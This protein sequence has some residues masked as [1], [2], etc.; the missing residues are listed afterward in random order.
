MPD[1]LPPTPRTEQHAGR[2]WDESP[3]ARYGLAAASAAAAALLTAALRFTAG[4]QNA[5]VIFAFFY[6]AVFVAVWFGGRGP[7]L[8]A[9][10]LSVVIADIFFLNSSILAPDLSGLIPNVFFVGISLIAVLLIERSRHAEA[11]ARVSR[12]SLETTLKSIGDAVISTDDAGRVVFMN[13]VAERLTKWPLADAL[14]RP[15]AEVFHIA[16]EET[17]R[18]VESPMEKVLRE[19]YV[20]GLANHTMLLARDGSEVPI[21]DSG[22]PIHDEEG[23]IRGVVLVFHDITERRRAEQI[24]RE[25]EQRS[26]LLAAIVESSDDAVIGKTLEG[27][28][29]SWNAAAERMYGYTS[30]EAVGRHISF[31]V[32][33]ELSGELQEIMSRLSRGERVEHLRTVRVRKDGQRLDASVT[34]SPILDSSG[35]WVGASTIARNIT[36]QKRTLERLRFVAEASRMLRSSL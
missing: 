31:I 2:T 11:E 10:A 24:Q 18:E 3:W 30:E 35:Q 7:G 8:F 20:V 27:V 13:P 26:R 23:R 17:R 34:I 25:T 4:A 21:D 22:A 6:V 33:P 1:A 16:N 15:L 5:R 36:E 29:T 12:E 19:G 14:S 9:I 32:P 28:I